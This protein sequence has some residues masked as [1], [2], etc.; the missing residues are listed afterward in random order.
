MVAVHTGPDQAA[1]AKLIL[2]LQVTTLLPFRGIRGSS[3]TV[4]STHSI[5]LGALIIQVEDDNAGKEVEARGRVVG[6]QVGAQYV[7]YC[8]ILFYTVLYC[9]HI[10][11]FSRFCL[12]GPCPLTK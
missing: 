4:L 1:K 11:Y 5:Q 8:S 9:R 12:P 6:L 2:V 3:V 7:L 10:I